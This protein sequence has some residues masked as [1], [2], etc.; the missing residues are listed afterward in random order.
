MRQGWVAADGA[1]SPGPDIVAG[2]ATVIA[3]SD[4]RARL[5]LILAAL[6]IPSFGIT[7]PAA[8]W[9]GLGSVRQQR[10]VSGGEPAMGFIALVLA[11]LSAMML[12]SVLQKT[13]VV[14]GAAWTWSGILWGVVL[15]TVAWVSATA[16][17]RIHP[18]RRGALRL[19][20]SC[21]ALATAGGT[22]LFVRLIAAL[23]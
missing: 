1:T 22:A 17:L 9:L 20:R 4:R 13:F 7:V 23:D 10:L 19:A 14:F 21:L 3:W 6:G 12:S 16:I 15:A 11:A 2:V 8:I 18:E 5:A